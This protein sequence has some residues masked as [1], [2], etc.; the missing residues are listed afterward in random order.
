MSGHSLSFLLHL[1]LMQDWKRTVLTSLCSHHHYYHVLCYGR[2]YQ[3]SLVRALKI[4]FRSTTIP[5]EI[6]QTLLNL[7]EFMEHD[8]ERLPIDLGILAELAQK[9]HAYAKALHYREEQ[10]LKNPV[11]CFER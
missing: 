7:A 2:P 10:F 8:V 5:P 6:L 9:G 1:P 3:E 11:S 4:A